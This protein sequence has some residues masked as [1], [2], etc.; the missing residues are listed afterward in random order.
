[1]NTIQPKIDSYV[2]ESASSEERLIIQD[3]FRIAGSDA[4]ATSAIQ[5]LRANKALFAQNPDTYEFLLGTFCSHI[6]ELKDQGAEI[7]WNQM[8]TFPESYIRAS[9]WLVYVM[10]GDHPED[11][12]ANAADFVRSRKE[13]WGEDDVRG[14]ALSASLAMLESDLVSEIDFLFEVLSRAVSPDDRR[15]AYQ[16]AAIAIKES[17]RWEFRYLIEQGVLEFPDV[18]V[19]AQAFLELQSAQS[20]A[21]SFVVDGGSYEN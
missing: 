3:V 16:Q 1:M 11:A 15:W 8:E 9:H 6:P 18:P 12:S 13:I 14:F 10:S 21:Q 7:L 5:K 19:I 2:G 17:G 20:N 4:G